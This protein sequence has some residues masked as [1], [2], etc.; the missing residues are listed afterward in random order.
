MYGVVLFAAMASAGPSCHCH[1]GPALCCPV[2]HGCCGVV[3]FFWAA[4]PYAGVA[5]A[6]DAKL[7]SDYLAALGDAERA[8]VMA[9]WKQSDEAGRLKLI[10]QVKANSPTT[11]PEKFAGRVARFPLSV[12][13]AEAQDKATKRLQIT[14]VV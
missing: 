10:A 1:S 14:H 6:G 9:L 11:R 8:D 2:S 4:T 12:G 3:R 13:A 7:W 5:S